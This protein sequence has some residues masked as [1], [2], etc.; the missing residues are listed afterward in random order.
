MAAAGSLGMPVREGMRQTAKQ[1]REVSRDRI[2]GD[3]CRNGGKDQH[4]A[5]GYARRHALAEDEYADHD[6]RQ[7]LQRT[8]HGCRRG[9][10]TR[11][12]QTNDSVVGKSASPSRL[13][14]IAAPCGITTPPP[15]NDLT[16]KSR[17]PN[18]S[19]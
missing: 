2:A 13:P 9:A 16:A 18:D 6:R 4:Y 11:E 5:A 8:Q 3:Q 10:D 15:A 1:P 14:H 7:R 19:T 17:R 12:M